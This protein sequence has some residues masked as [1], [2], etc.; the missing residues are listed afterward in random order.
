VFVLLLS[1][2][3]PGTARGQAP[4]ASQGA[5]A[6]TAQKAPADLANAPSEE[7]LRAYAQL[8]QL[9]SGEQFAVAENV[10]FKRD[11]GTFTF[12]DGRLVSAAPVAGHVVAAVFSGDATFEL[13]PPTPVARR[14]I[15]RFT[16]QPKLTE[17]FH[18]AVFFFS[19]DSWAELQKLAR[20]RSGGAPDVGKALEAAQRQISESYN[21]WWE[22]LRRGNFPVRNLAARLLADLSDPSSRGFFLAQ[23]RSEQYGT[24]FYHVSWN[25]D[26]VLPGYPNDTDEEVLLVRSKRDNYFEWWSGFHLAEEYAKTPYPEHRTLLAHCRRQHIE[27]DLSNDRLSAT[28]DLE[29]EIPAGTPRVIPFN[30]AGVL[31][32]SSLTDYVGQ[33]LAFI[34]EDRRLDSDPWLLLV[35]PAE[36]GRIY[37]LK[38]TYREDSTRDSRIVQQQGSGL[39]FVT[40]RESWFPSF[41][42]FD[43]RTNFTLHFRSPKKFIFVGTGRRTQAEKGSDALET[44]WESEIPLGVVGFNYGDFVDKTQSDPNLTVTAYSGRE[45]PDEL[46]GL[47]KEIDLANLAAG[48]GRTG[49]IRDTASQLGIMT[50][51]FNTAHMAGY[52]AGTSYQ[53]L[54]LFEFYFGDLPFKTVSVTEQPVRG[55]GQSWPTLIFLPYDSLL[56][57]TTRHSLHLQDSPE[58]IE[59]YNIVAVHEMAHQW[60]GHLVGWKTYHDQWLSEGFA[61]FSASLYLRRFEP[62]KVNSFWE[63]KRKWLLNANLQ[64]HRPVDIGP[65]WLNSQLNAHLEERNAYTLIYFKG[66]YVLEMLRVLME[67]ARAQ[68]PDERFIRMLHDFTTTYA[69]KNASTEDFRRI[70][71]KHMGEP[72]DWFFNEWVYGTE[73]PHYRLSYQLKDAGGGKTAVEFSLAQS[74]VSEDFQMRVPFFVWTGGKP[75]RLGLLVVRGTTPS[76]GSFTLPLRPEKI[77]LDEGHSLLAIY[78][79]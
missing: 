54:K 18:E 43:D 11:A 16:K 51:G 7:L 76:T 33:K 9:R 40:A 49:E 70:V 62:N 36:P 63:L 47:E 48:P 71:E 31:R 41:G 26:P 21:A 55:F 73:I 79:Q 14:Q 2:G 32:I 59:F 29:I 69:G 10:V 60:W 13:N 67:N 22:S 6:A 78:S 74:G 4:R 15:F 20:V 65:L 53:A 28:A 42:A 68:N 23:I 39:F 46:K 5:A 30:L 35:A 72:M 61:E 52:A 3:L 50:G 57:S 34:Q 19:D 66:A 44:A 24:L 64:S 17:S 8:R 45:V 25:R 12:R 77:S 58:A 38:I 37:K 27:A 75:R 1:L 56:D